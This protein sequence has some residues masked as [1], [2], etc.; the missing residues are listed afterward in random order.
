MTQPTLRKRIRRGLLKVEELHQL[1]RD[2]FYAK[3]GRIGAREIHHQMNACS[4]LTLIAASVIYW[5]AREIT[6]ILQNSNFENSGFSPEL[7]RHI[8]PIGWENVI[9]YGQ[10]KLNPDLIQ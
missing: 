2:I 6:N 8:S 1:A 3:R 9:L 5:Q 4:S 7:L 10:Y